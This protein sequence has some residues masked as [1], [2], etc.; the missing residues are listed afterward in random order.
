MNRCLLALLLTVCGTAPVAANDDAIAA[1][2]GCIHNLDPSLDVGYR[3][4]AERCPEL[5]GALAA[6]PYAAWLPPDWSKPDNELSVGGLIELRRLLTRTEP[7][8]AVRIPRVAQLAD[9]LQELHRSDTAPRSG[10][11]R[12]KQWLR[13][14]FTP[15]PG[16]AEQGWLARVIGGIDLSQRITRAIVWGALLLLLLLAGAVVA[17]E[18]RVAGWWRRHRRHGW[19]PAAHAVA[20]RAAGGLEDVER[21]SGDEQP[22]LLLQLIIQRLIELQRLPPARALTLKELERAARL[23]DEL[24]RERLAALSAACER[25]RYA[26]VV[27]ATVLAAASSRGRELFA[28]LGTLHAQPSEAG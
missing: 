8:P 17:N 11:A 19:H 12:L 9:V 27:S 1:I 5:A 21:A 22:H 10:W 20:G 3:H 4:V 13:G 15:Q 7:T 23:P 28:S 6:S 25:A 2:D 16:D 24:D 18:L 14:V 26:E